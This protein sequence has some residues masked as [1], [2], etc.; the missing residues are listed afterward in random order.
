M[1]DKTLLKII[2]ICSF[3]SGMLLGILPLFPFLV[4]FGI[5]VQMFLT[6]PFIIIY[7]KQLNLISQIETDKCLIIG[8]ISGFSS[9]LGFSLIFLPGSFILNLIFKIDAFLWIKVLFNNLGFIIPMIIFAGLLSALLNMF[10]GL[11]TVY[12]YEYFKKK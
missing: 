11:L 12:I 7:L 4:Q 10:S 6:A 1:L 3:F 5:L 9:F 8:A 2:C